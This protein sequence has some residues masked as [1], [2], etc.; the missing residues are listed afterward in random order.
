MKMMFCAEEEK[1]PV[2]KKI[3]DKDSGG[4]LTESLLDA[5]IALNPSLTRLDDAAFAAG[6]RV[7]VRAAH[8]AAVK[9][10]G[11]VSGIAG[12]GSGPAPAHAGFVGGGG[13]SWRH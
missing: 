9:G 1:E 2:V 7:V 12:G 13:G 10:K 3:L 8:A 4:E 6:C 11:K 5:V